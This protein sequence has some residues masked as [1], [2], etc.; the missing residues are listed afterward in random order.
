MRLCDGLRELDYGEWEGKSPEEVN[1]DHH[2]DYFRW[3]AD[4]GRNSPTGGKR[5]VDVGLRAIA[6]IEE[7][8]REH[9]DGDVLMVSHKATI[10]ILPCHFLGIDIGCYRDRIKRFGRFPV[11]GG[12][13]RARPLALP[14]E[15]PSALAASASGASGHLRDNILFADVKNREIT[16]PASPSPYS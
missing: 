16:A 6:V 4:V 3:L 2:A 9:A 5:G 10:R 12:I 13:A 11:R 7:I 15:R 8:W 1:R 14:S